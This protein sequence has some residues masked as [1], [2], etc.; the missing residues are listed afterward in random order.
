MSLKFSIITASFNNGQT[1]ADTIQSVQAQ[2]YSHIEHIV[3]DGA[4]T[5]NTLQI[6]HAMQR[7]PDVII[8]EPDNGIYDAFNKGIALASGDVIGFLNADDFLANPHI[9]SRL[10]FAMENE[11]TDG[12]YA[13]LVYVKKDDADKIVRTWV[14]GK[15]VSNSFRYGWMPPHPTF[16]LKKSWYLKY[17]QYRTDMISAADYELMLRMVHKNKATL[18][19]INET[20]VNMRMGGISNKNLKNRLRANKEDQRAW[21]LNGLNMPWYTPILKPA[22]KLTQFF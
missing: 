1:I 12:A 16:Y 7:R 8:S 21:L 17:G 4:S 2:D 3:V 15:Y 5:D 6:I 14:A 9:I 13:N 10:A 18:S 20:M 22:R 19:Y 11:N